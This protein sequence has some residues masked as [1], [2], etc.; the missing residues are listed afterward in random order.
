MSRPANNIQPLKNGQQKVLHSICF[1]RR[2]FI[3]FFFWKM[4]NFSKILTR[5]P[6][7]LVVICKMNNKPFVFGSLFV[8]VFLILT[9]RK[10]FLLYRAYFSFTTKKKKNLLTCVFGCTGHQKMQQNFSTKT[11][12]A[13]IL[14]FDP[15]INT[16]YIPTNR[17]GFL[18]VQHRANLPT[19]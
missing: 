18:P 8:V 11:S 9:S 2:P 6:I 12:W 1:N 3:F 17:T 5:F 10:L 15:K 19:E 14:L 4:T 7:C 13:L 16:W